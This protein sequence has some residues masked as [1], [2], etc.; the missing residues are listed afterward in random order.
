MTGETSNPTAATPKW[1][2]SPGRLQPQTIKVQNTG[3]PRLYRA[4]RQWTHG[5]NANSPAALKEAGRITD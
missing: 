3:Q 1:N 5:R 4:T 2:P